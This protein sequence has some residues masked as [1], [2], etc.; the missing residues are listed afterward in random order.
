MAMEHSSIMM[1]CEW[2]CEGTKVLAA[3]CHLEHSV[4]E[5]FLANSTLVF[6]GLAFV[7]C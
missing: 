3:H 5:G 1:K 6:S 4:F 2:E 7:E